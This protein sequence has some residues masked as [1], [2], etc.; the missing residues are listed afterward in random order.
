MQVSDLWRTWSWTR[1]E[2]EKSSSSEGTGS[3]VDA[4]SSDGE[5]GTE[6]SN[7]LGSAAGTS[8]SMPVTSA[9]ARGRGACKKHT[10]L[11]GC[12][13]AFC[14]EA[15][16]LG[17][18]AADTAAYVGHGSVNSQ[19]AYQSNTLRSGEPCGVS[20]K[21][22]LVMALLERMHGPARAA[23][24]CFLFLQ[25]GWPCRRSRQRA[26]PPSEELRRARR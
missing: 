26:H 17:A 1:S 19:K 22:R 18:D 16:M 6:A 5:R 21:Y 8:S 12:R 3:S 25:A 2:L 10:T 15:L 9:P 11:R 7:Q 4:G 13:Y 24:L 23:V 20:V 14:L